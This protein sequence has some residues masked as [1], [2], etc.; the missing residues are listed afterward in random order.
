FGGGYAQRLR[1]GA[2]FSLNANRSIYTYGN[3]EFDVNGYDVTI[4]S[5]IS[6]PGGPCTV[7]AGTVTLTNPDNDYTGHVYASAGI[8]RGDSAGVWGAPPVTG[9][10]LLLLFGGT[11][12]AGAS[13]TMSAF[14]VIGAGAGGAIDTMDGVTLTV[15]AQVVPWGGAFN[16]TGPGTLKLTTP[17]NTADMIVHEGTMEVNSANSLS[18]HS[19]A[20]LKPD[21]VLTIATDLALDNANVNFTLGSTSDRIVT[22]TLSASNVSALHFT[23]AAG[24][25]TGA[26]HL[27]DYTAW[28]AGSLA[29]LDCPAILGKWQL[30]LQDTGTALVLHVI[31]NVDMT[32]SP[33][34]P[35]NFGTVGVSTIASAQTVT[36]NNIGGSDVNI[37][38][39]TVTGGFAFTLPLPGTPTYAVASGASAVYG[40]ELP[41]QS[42]PGHYA[43]TATFVT[44]IADGAGFKT[45][46]YDL[47]AD[48]VAHA[49]DV[50]GDGQVS[51]L[52]YN[53]I[54]A[55]FGN[56]YAD[57]NHWNDGDVNSDLQVGLLDF[58]IV[59]AH[60]GHT[61][62]DGAA[63][64]A[65]PEPASMLAL[66]GVALPMLLKRRAKD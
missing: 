51:L 25:A 28:N 1:W 52:D 53:I 26:I 58:N 6:G 54:K 57:G 30:S 5:K 19:G 40:I 15:P 37:T 32:A 43:G 46:T 61:T 27:I 33:A 11:V 39:A 10:K 31:S 44:D 4:A 9:D 38:A 41:G 7:S 62:G 34:G 56:A 17:A 8:L 24:L 22:S 2:N 47:A 55:H 36:L 63:L 3:A 66:L 45:F 60:F 21:G 48:V 65:V 18:V 16:K 35:F 64:T 50:N 42:T 59:K 12:Q 13:H 14:T 29:N 20:A 23:E 49:G